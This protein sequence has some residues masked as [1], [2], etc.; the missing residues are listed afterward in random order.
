MRS[1][2]RLVLG[3]VFRVRDLPHAL[4]GKPHCSHD[5][6]LLHVLVVG[7]P[8]GSEKSRVGHFLAALGA[9]IPARK[10]GQFGCIHDL[11]ITYANPLDKRG[12]GRPRWLA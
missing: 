7:T 10:T 8:D 6:G 12:A 11:T 1:V 2:A 3:P 5:V 4:A 9:L